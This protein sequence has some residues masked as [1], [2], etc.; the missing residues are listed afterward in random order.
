MNDPNGYL[1]AFYYMH[2]LSATDEL[3]PSQMRV[4]ARMS[5][6]IDFEAL[7]ISN[8]PSWSVLLTDDTGGTQVVEVPKALVAEGLPLSSNLQV[9]TLFLGRS[10]YLLLP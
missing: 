9:M 3:S 4:P 6:R 5:S 10:F 1:F 2:V 7:G 8:P